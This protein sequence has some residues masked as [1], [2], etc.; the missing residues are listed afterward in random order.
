M[1]DTTKTRKHAPYRKSFLIPIW[2][3]QLGISTFIVVMAGISLTEDSNYHLNRPISNH[4]LQTAIDTF[5][6]LLNLAVAASVNLVIG[7]FANFTLTTRIY[8]IQSILAVVL[9]TMC[10]VLYCV[11]GG[12]EFLMAVFPAAAWLASV[13]VC[14]RVCLL[15]GRV[16]R[17]EVGEMKREVRGEERDVEARVGVELQNVNKFRG[18]DEGMAGPSVMVTMRAGLES[19]GP[20]PSFHS[21]GTG[22][23]GAPEKVVR[24]FV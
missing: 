16:G 9:Y 23:L 5:H 17:G 15:R 22:I 11:E 6:V 4:S 21:Q 20:R 18:A 24:E 14:W 3:I 13:A 19:A 8:K 12:G 2:V 7:R 10:I 1:A